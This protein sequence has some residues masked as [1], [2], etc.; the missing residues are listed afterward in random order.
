MAPL[1]PRWMAVSL[2]ATQAFAFSPSLRVPK[3]VERRVVGRATT[4]E[5][6]PASPGAETSGRKHFIRNIIED[7]LASGKHK[8]IITR[9]PPEPNGISFKS[10]GCD[11]HCDSCR[12]R[13]THPTP[14]SS[15][16]ASRPLE[17]RFRVFAHW[18]CQVDLPELRAR[19]ILPGLHAHAF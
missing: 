2:L 14:W 18:A 11:K 8:S 19:F 17:P 4:E 16:T 6:A 7:D 3:A 10:T 1:M 15:L 9:F 13:P 5:A 12:L